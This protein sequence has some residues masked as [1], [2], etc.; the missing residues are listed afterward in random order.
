MKDGFFVSRI[1]AL[2]GERD[3]DFA[4]RENVHTQPGT[5]LFEKPIQ[6]KEQRL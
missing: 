1:S 6:N 2:Q 3:F 4:N 5:Q